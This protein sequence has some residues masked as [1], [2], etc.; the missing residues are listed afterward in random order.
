MKLYPYRKVKDRI[1]WNKG[2]T[3]NDFPQ[4]SNS[5]VK[6]GNKPWNLGKKATIE[7][8]KKLSLSHI[9]QKSWNKGNK[10]YRAGIPRIPIGF[11]MSE[12]TKKKMKLSARRGVN[13]HLWKGGLP[14]CKYCNIELKSYKSIQCVDCYHKRI[15]KE[16][17]KRR[18]LI[19]L[20]KQQN[21][22]GPTSIEK[23]LYKELMDRGL[24]FEKQKL[25]NGKFLVDAYIPSL[26][27]IIEA[28]GDYWHSL[29]RVVKKDKAENAYL[30]K[31]GYKLLRLT[32]SEII[33]GSFKNKIN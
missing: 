9:G 33:E 18:M 4:M 12:E 27:L 14:L 21:M 3:K 25:I 28:D 17:Y 19:A 2:K 16:E 23:K 31:C 5:G 26:N 7:I 29:D 13:S 20:E 8:R 32:E 11:K 15:N 24:L 30:T 10:G 1:P 22:K 6:K